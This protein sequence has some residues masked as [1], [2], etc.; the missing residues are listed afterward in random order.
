MNLFYK[1]LFLL[2][3][4]SVIALGQTNVITN[5][6]MENWTGG[7]PDGWLK[8]TTDYDLSQNTDTVYAGSSSARILLQ[9]TTTQKFRQDDIPIIGGA[10]YTLQ[11]RV[12]DNDTAGRVRFWGY[13]DGATGG[14]QPSFYT[15]DIAG[16]QLYEYEIDAPASATSL[17]LEVRFYDESASWDGDALF[18]LDEIAV[19]AP[20]TNAP[21]ISN[22]TT[23]HFDAGVGID[24]DAD[25]TDDQGIDEAWLHSSTDLGVTEDSILMSNTSGDTYQGTIPAQSNNATLQY[26]VSATDTDG[27]NYSTSNVLGTIIGIADISRAHELD[28]NGNM[29]YDNF[30]AKIK[31]IVTVATGTFSS[32]AQDDYMQDNTGGINVFDF[33][34]IQTLALG[35]SVEVEGKFSSYNAK[36]EI[37]DFSINVFSFGNP[38]PAPTVITTIEMAEQYEGMLIQINQG[39]ISNW[40]S[41]PPDTNFNALL[42][43]ADGDLTLRVDEDTDIGGHLTPAGIIDV[44]GIGSQNDYS[45]PFTEGYQIMPRSW[46][47]F[48]FPNSI[49]EEVNTPYEFSLKQNYPNPFNPNTKIEYSLAKNSD[50]KMVIYNMLGQEIKS[51]T[52]QNLAKGKHHFD[53]NGTDNKGFDVASGVYIYRLTADDPSTSSGQRFIS[54]KKMAL[55][56]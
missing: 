9:S 12:Y 28:A 10:H 11:M 39:A 27:P 30:L 31:G 32:T 53:W 5:G 49:D 43:T 22:V 19:L 34:V 40:V 23:G 46:A 6:G 47:D 7:V 50:V 55:L 48:L 54:T 45:S 15:S 41:Q 3:I 37:V 2:L 36:S 35:D 56:R 20:S 1:T 13:W 44:I 24:I 52:V 25:I 51:F 16:W 14:P 33:A 8:H 18:Y 4:I 42:T 29:L 26:W 17:D 38:V 21:L